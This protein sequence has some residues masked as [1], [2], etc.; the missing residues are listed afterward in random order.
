[1]LV[2]AISNFAGCKPNLRLA[3]GRAKRLPGEC[4]EGEVR[5]EKAKALYINQAHGADGEPIAASAKYLRHV[6]TIF[7]IHAPPTNDMVESTRPVEA[8]VIYSVSYCIAEKAGDRQGFSLTI[9]RWAS[10]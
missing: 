2:T 10:Y 7:E 9:P 6:I 5:L 4:C 1:M 3:Q 8:D